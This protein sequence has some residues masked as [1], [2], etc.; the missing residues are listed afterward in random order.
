[1]NESSISNSFAQSVVSIFNEIYANFKSFIAETDSA[2]VQ[3][4]EG[5]EDGIIK[6]A[7]PAMEYATKTFKQVTIATET[8]CGVEPSWISFWYVPNNNM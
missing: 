8:L 7:I 4:G 5:R 2:A 1:M 3:Q 6:N